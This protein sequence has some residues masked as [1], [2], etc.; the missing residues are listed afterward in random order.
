MIKVFMEL[1]IM[2]R[3][4]VDMDTNKKN[5]KWNN[6]NHNLCHNQCHNQCHSH[7]RNHNLEAKNAINT[8]YFTL[9]PAEME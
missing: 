4:K 2:E 1:V 5:K 3:D 9:T 6:L 7:N 8:F